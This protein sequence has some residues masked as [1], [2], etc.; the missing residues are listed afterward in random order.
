[1][2]FV[3]TCNTSDAAEFAVGAIAYSF[4]RFL[5]KR[6]IKQTGK[7]VLCVYVSGWF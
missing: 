4:E 6:F 2:D 5:D 7:L 1:M 3:K